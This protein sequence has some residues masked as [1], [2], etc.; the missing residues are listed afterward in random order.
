MEELGI[1][2]DMPRGWIKGEGQPK[3]H[4]VV[5]SLWKGMHERV[6]DPKHPSYEWYKD[7]KIFSDYDFLSNYVN[8]ILGEPTFNE[9]IQT[10]DEVIWSVDKADRDYYPEYMSLV[11]QSENSKRRIEDKGS[12]NKGNFKPIIGIAL[13][14]SLIIFNSVN[15]AKEKGF[16]GVYYSLN[17]KGKLYKGYEWY[18]LDLKVL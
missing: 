14:N 15:E 4:Q 6:K 18:Y 1:K 7:C 11:T 17:N 13:D 12:P 10:C 16:K 8:F 2:N 3:W 5:Y 9:F